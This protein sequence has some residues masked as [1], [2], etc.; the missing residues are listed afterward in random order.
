MD[1]LISKVIALSLL[2]F[3]TL[4]FG[5][6]PI[7]LYS[8][9]RGDENSPTSTRRR[10]LAD[11]V[12]SFLLH[13]GGGVL[14]ATS[15]LHMI[16]EVRENLIKA[17][18][19]GIL[20]QTSY[21]FAELFVCTGFFLVYSIELI[22]HSCLQHS[23]KPKKTTN[24]E[25][26]NL[27]QAE[28]KLC[29]HDSTKMNSV[30][31]VTTTAEPPNKHKY[32]SV[33]AVSVIEDLPKSSRSAAFRGTLVIAALSFHSIFEGMAVGLQP[34]SN[35]VWT[36]LTAIAIH[37]LVIAFCVGVELT[38]IG[39]KFVIFFIQ[40]LILATVSPI[41]VGIGIIVMEGAAEEV[42]TNGLIIGV[43]QGLAAGTLIYVTFFEILIKD[44]ERQSCQFGKLLCNVAGFS[45]IAA[46]QVLE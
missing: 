32:G 29:A 7:K 30:D 27:D 39:T 38:S 28:T 4:A 13:F 5:L 19:Y 12:V 9:L 14:L 33:E 41:G 17:A 26:R 21:P 43:F 24:S 10:K 20:P 2:G 34:S 23:K 31:I 3:L 6:A 11:L 46:A 8:W 45:M 15:F 18:K 1:V 16:P 42:T 35:G 25:K 37:K 44:I 36:L 22:A 40:I